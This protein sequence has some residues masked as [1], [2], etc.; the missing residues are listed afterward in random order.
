MVGK[1]TFGLAAALAMRRALSSYHYTPAFA[2]IGNEDVQRA[3][4][5]ARRPRLGPPPARR[6]RRRRVVQQAERL[7]WNPRVQI[8]TRV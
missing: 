7:A 5:A 4:L 2:R 6:Q 8:T 1:L 3:M